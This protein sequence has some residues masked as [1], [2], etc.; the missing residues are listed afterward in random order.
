MRAVMDAYN[1]LTERLAA[2]PNLPATMK[3][4]IAHIKDRAGETEQP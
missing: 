2:Y 3:E 4:L 1:E